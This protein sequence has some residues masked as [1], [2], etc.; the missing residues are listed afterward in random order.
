VSTSTLT[1][2]GGSITVP[3]TG[4]D[5]AAAYQLLITPAAGPTSS[6]QQVYEAENATVV[7]A[8]TLASPAASNGS[9]VGRIDNTDMR[10]TASSTSS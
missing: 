1:V 8:L 7:N 5:A 9:Y 10:T 4:M 6:Y 2:T 3:V